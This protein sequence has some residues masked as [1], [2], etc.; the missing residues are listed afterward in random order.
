LPRS[1]LHRRRHRP[2]ENKRK[3]ELQKKKIEPRK[4]PVRCRKMEAT[5]T[6]IEIASENLHVLFSPPVLPPFLLDT[7]ETMI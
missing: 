4:I 1:G 6:S 5:A 7:N 3:V 2:K